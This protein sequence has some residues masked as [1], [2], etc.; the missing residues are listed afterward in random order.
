MASQCQNEMRIS[1]LAQLILRGKFKVGELS[2]QV[3][4]GMMFLKL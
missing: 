2:P 4:I 3:F 1:D